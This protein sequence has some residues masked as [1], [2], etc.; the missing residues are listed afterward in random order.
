MKKKLK[1]DQ[2]SQEQE[3]QNDDND[4]ESQDDDQ[5]S[6]ERDNGLSLEAM[7]AE[8]RRARREAAKYRTDL[9]KLEK[10]DE[11][12]KRSEMSEVE[13]L[14]ADLEAAKKLAE[15]AT[16]AAREQALHNAVFAEA[17]KTEYNV[18]PDALEVLWKEIDRSALE[19]GDNGKIE[20][21]ADELKAVLTRLP[22]LQQ[23]KS[24]TKNSITPT[25]PEGGQTGL[26]DEQLRKK[27]FGGAGHD[28]FWKGAGVVLLGETE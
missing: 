28:T 7:G 24:K 25:N 22:F 14:K 18:R 17:I 6:P 19:V 1:E 10:T 16:E 3:V 5:K 23:G 12:R 21:L 27:L 11:E 15:I 9:R 2:E 20:G 4:Q 8:L 13:Q 26:T